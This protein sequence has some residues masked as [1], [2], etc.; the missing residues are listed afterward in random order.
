MRKCK[1]TVVFLDGRSKEFVA[2]QELIF[3]TAYM[4]QQSNAIQ[5]MKLRTED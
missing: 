1:L 3:A 5:K 4:F 2:D